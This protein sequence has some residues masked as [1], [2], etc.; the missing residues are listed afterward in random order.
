MA[1]DSK[2]DKWYPLQTDPGQLFTLP[3][4]EVLYKTGT[5]TRLLV[6]DSSRQLVTSPYPSHNTN[7]VWLDVIGGIMILLPAQVNRISAVVS[8][9]GP[10][11]L[12]VGC[13]QFDFQKYIRLNVGEYYEF[14]N[15]VLTI[16]VYSESDTRAVGIEFM[17]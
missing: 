10:A 7:S 9:H 14:K 4:G 13:D 8:N 3:Y 2:T 12:Y 6:R 1:Y 11:V 16:Y 15:Y 17:P 5:F